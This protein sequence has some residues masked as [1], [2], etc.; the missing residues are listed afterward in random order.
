MGDRV[1]SFKGV[2]AGF[3]DARFLADHRFSDGGVEEPA[4]DY[5]LDRVD[6]SRR[7]HRQSTMSDLECSMFIANFIG[8][9]IR[10]DTL[11]SDRI[12]SSGRAFGSRFEPDG[13]GASRALDA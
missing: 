1:G 2:C 9:Y 7:K 10:H 12:N 3:G 5:T 8:Q 11:D 6:L 4:E 13:A